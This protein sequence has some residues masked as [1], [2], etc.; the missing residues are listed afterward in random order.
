MPLA[1]QPRISFTVIRVPLIVGLPNLMPASTV[2]K[3]FQLLFILDS[4]RLT[5]DD[6]FKV[7]YL[8]KL[9]DNFGWFQ[10]HFFVHNNNYKVPKN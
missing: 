5:Q 10:W 2:I 9:G 8:Q 6:L 4:L 3:N 1:N 7:I